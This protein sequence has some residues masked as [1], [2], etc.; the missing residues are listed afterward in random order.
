MKN[1]VFITILFLT[2]SIPA[3]AQDCEA[4]ISKTD[5]MT[6]QLV[7]YWGGKI[8][9]Q[10][11]ILTGKGYDA[12]FYLGKDIENGNAPIAI[13]NLI[14]KVPATDADIFDVNFDEGKPYLIKTEGGL[15]EMPVSRI[16]K[17][18]NRFL[19]TYSVQIQLI[20]NLTKENAEQLANNTILMFRA[21]SSNGQ[22]IDGKVGKKDAKR[23][24]E[25]FSCFLQ[26]L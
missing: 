20:G 13:L 3:F 1:S 25:Q 15:I 7:E 24:Q 16:D 18:N 21:T 2:T 5:E 10:S 11:T 14:Y 26:K 23:L 4:K 9:G 12:D 8:G 17:S 19:E 6:D 22:S